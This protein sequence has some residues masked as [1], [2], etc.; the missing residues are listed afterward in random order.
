MMAPLKRPTV[1]ICL[2]VATLVVSSWIAVS[3]RGSLSSS[4]G[5]RELR[6]YGGV[7]N[8]QLGRGE[9]WRLLTAQFVHVKP[10]HMLF[11]V[12]TLFLLATAVERAAGSL[13]LAF[14]WLVSGIAGMYAS[15]YGV[16]PP[17][18]V[19]T[20]ASQALM[21]IA[22]ATLVVIRRNN[23]AAWL[24]ATLMMTLVLQLGLDVR[25]AY[26]PKPGHVVG[27]AVGLFLAI[28]LVP[29]KSTS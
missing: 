18:D 14:L 20:G 12:I 26:Y 9:Y 21:G 23:D 10:A 17:Y 7:D 25:V 24:K 27:F 19:G 4:V 11:N 8:A 1:S 29:R 16:P 28:L 15:I 5:V 3:L 6:N 2:A 22:G 13:V